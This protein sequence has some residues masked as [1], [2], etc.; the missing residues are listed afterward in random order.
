MRFGTF[1]A[2]LLAG[3]LLL[4]GCS[5]Q[6]TPAAETPTSETANY[7]VQITGTIDATQSRTYRFDEQY[8][9]G[10]YYKEVVIY[11]YTTTPESMYTRITAKLNG[12]LYQ[13]NMLDEDGEGATVH[14]STP[15]ASYILYPDLKTYMQYEPKESSAS[16]LEIYSGLTF[17]TGTIQ[18]RGREYA[19]ERYTNG[20]VITSYCF[21][22]E[23]MRFVLFQSPLGDT[24]WEYKTVTTEVD[25]ALFEIPADYTPA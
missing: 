5:P 1:S 18:I 22:G 11:D 23:M 20:G 9:I 2:L 4:C 21:E 13:K 14:I 16:S 12:A 15:E 10:N 24:L 7:P 19:L 6:N 25:P 3:L 17:Q 8:T